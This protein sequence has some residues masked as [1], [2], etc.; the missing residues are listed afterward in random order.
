M[1]GAKRAASR[2]IRPRSPQPSHGNCTPRDLC[3]RCSM[4]KVIQYRFTVFRR[5]FGRDPLPGEPLLF[6]PEAPTAV[7]PD[8]RQTIAQLS[9]AAKETGVN[10]DR[11]LKFLN[12]K[13]PGPR[14]PERGFGARTRQAPS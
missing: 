9:E 10:L 8:E 6:A 1:E 11:L 12:I 5:T 3:A 7:V 14:M 4:M 13:R 2:S